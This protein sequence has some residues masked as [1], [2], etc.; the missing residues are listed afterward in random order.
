[1]ALR[2]FW[3]YSIGKFLFGILVGQ[4]S[5]CLISAKNSWEPI[6]GGGDA[7]GCLQDHTMVA[8]RSLFDSVS[9]GCFSIIINTTYLGGDKNL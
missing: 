5:T 9:V 4:V 7:P 2:D 1:M 6:R 3:R 8:F